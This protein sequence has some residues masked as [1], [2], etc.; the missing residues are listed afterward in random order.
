MNG[1]TQGTWLDLDGFGFVNSISAINAIE[2]LRVS[3][4]NPANGA[5]VTVT[6]SRRHGHLQQGREFLD[7]QSR[8]LDLH[9]DARPASPSM[10]GTPIAVDNPI[11]PTIVQFPI[12]FTKPSGTL[13]NG[14][15]AF[16]I[17]SLAA[18][19]VTAKDGKTLVASGKIS[20][21][22]ADVTSPVIEGTKLSGRTVQIQFS[23]ALDPATVTL[24]NIFVI[25]KGSASVWPPSSTNYTSYTDLNNDP[26]ATISY[27]T[28]INPSSG[29]PTYTVT[30][31][32][33][34]LPQTEM[35]SD[36]YAIVVLSKNAGEHRRDRPGRQPARRQFHRLVPVRRRRQA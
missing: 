32:Y 20:F 19:T 22:L 17:Q 5:T 11:F 29:Q 10:S 31:N 30:L 9:C 26:R 27:T 1:Q 15:Y 12:S 35:P 24:Q 4:T 7:D 28:G 34:G 21:T 14:A 2:L 8:R 18:E 16:T 33:D 36:Q 25:R 23:K 13:A 3:S 6:P